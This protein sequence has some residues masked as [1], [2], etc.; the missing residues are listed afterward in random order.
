[1]SA[2]T[3]V[4]SYRSWILNLARRELAVRHKR[5]ILGWTWSLINPAATLAIYAA[6]F[7]AFL[8]MEPPVAGNGTLKN[9][10]VYLFI[11]LV[12]WNFFNAVVNGSMTGLSAAGP[13]LSKV[14]FPP[15]SPAIANLL[16][17]LVQVGLEASIAA[18]LLI[19]L[20]NVSW[21][22]LLWPPIILLLAM[23]SL[24]F[25]LLVSV[26]NI[27]Y[28]DVAYLVGIFMQM[29]FY[30]TPI[31]YPIDIVNVSF[32]GI[33]ARWVIENLNPLTSFVESTR[34]VMYLL[35]V[36]RWHDWLIMFGWSAGML[37]LGWF[38]FGR[39]AADLI[40]EL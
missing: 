9:F 33:D 22:F 29:L 34:D 21:T 12:M 27:V 15:E 16:A 25:G 38:A 3:T 10:A 39:K 18:L 19:V 1:M 28:R 26:Y 6:V 5:S 17:A 30:A 14:Y 11:A 36:P 4:W 32:A 23:F 35:E 8:R 13:M 2:P 31:V 20:G 7:G 40:E 24:G 37:V